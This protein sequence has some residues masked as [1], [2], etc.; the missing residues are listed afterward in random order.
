[1]FKGLNAALES[2]ARLLW[3]PPGNVWDLMYSSHFLGEFK[4]DPAIRNWKVKLQERA[5]QQT[6]LVAVAMEF[7]AP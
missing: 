5:S 1:V 2:K 4:K 7:Q 3:N 6:Q